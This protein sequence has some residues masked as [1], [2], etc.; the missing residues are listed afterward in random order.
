MSDTANPSGL[1]PVYRPGGDVWTEAFKGGFASGYAANVFAGDPLVRLTGG[2]FQKAAAGSG[3]I[4]DAV[5]AG[6]EYRDSDGRPTV[7]SNWASGTVATDVVVYA[8]VDPSI[9]YEIQA[10]DTLTDASVGDAGVVALGT[11]NSVSGQSTS[12]FDASTLVGAGNA[13]ALKIVGLG[14]GIDNAWGDDYP[15]V[16]VILG[17]PAAFVPGNAI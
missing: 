17:R 7:R 3:Q 16:K 15:T 14:N 1:R 13:S 9:V 5:F 10:D 4:I 11:G 12:V 6:V 8:Y 2:G